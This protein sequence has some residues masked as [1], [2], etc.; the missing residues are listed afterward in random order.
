MDG[1]L[2][3]ADADSRLHESLTTSN[4]S[5]QDDGVTLTAALYFITAFSFDLIATSDN[6]K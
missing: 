1:K 4:E 3:N 6:F 2:L 5:E